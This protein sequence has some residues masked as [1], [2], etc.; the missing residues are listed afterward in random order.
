MAKLGIDGERLYAR[1]GVD[2]VNTRLRHKQVRERIRAGL[3][4]FRATTRN[5]FA[6]DDAGLTIVRA[7][8]N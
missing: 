8:K 2:P 3:W 5:A 6:G 4:A 1:P 7:L